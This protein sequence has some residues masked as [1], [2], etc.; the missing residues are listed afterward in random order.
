M[1]YLPQSKFGDCQLCTAKNTNCIK[2]G[3]VLMC[4]SCA[5]T[6]STKKQIDKANE[7]NKVRSLNTSDAN[8]E[9]IGGRDVEQELW[10]IHRSKEMVGVCAEC[11]SP[12]TKGDKTYWKYSICHILAKSLFPSVAKHPLNFIELCYFYN[13]HHTNMDNNG[14]EYVREKMPNAWKIIVVRFKAMYPVIKEKSKIPDCLLQ[15]LDPSN[16]I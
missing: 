7:R 14:Y 6:Q 2:R 1:S 4:L 9:V 8:K 12:S 10:Y 16:E 15:E 11:K 5:R 3:K 13:S